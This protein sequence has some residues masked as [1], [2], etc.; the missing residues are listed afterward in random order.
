MSSLVA[1]WHKSIKEIQEFDW[2]ALS[3]ESVIP[4]YEWQWLD[5]LEKSRS[6]SPEQGWQ[7]LHLS[8]SRSNKLIAVAPLYLKGH[9]YGEFVFDQA[10]ARLAESLNVKYY[11]KL[12]GMS[13]LSPVEG[14]RFFIDQKENKDEITN[15]MMKIIDKFAIK[16][17]IC[18]CNFLYVEPYWRTLAEKSGCSTWLNQQSLWLANDQKNFSDYLASF[19]SNQRR[20]IKRERK[21]VKEAGVLISTLTGE[22]ID[23]NVMRNMHNFYQAHCARWGIWGS[24]YLSRTFFERLPL[25]S[26]RDHLILFNAH[27]G[28]PKDPIAMSLCVTNREKLWGRYWGSKEE[29]ECLHFEVCYY[30]PIEWALNNGIKS[31]DPGAGGN[32]KRRRGFLAKPHA[33]LHR[34]YNPQMKKLIKNW[35]PKVNQLML[36]EIDAIN[37]ELP[38][39]SSMPRIPLSG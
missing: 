29:V 28:N 15:L 9:S 19:N 13:P 10:F 24:K 21:S 5:T 32:H 27:K 17:G 38:F 37:A 20:N 23:T 26:Q 25:T 8:L 6:V 36:E 4:F 16:N 33:S 14:Y 3:G 39:H 11:P 31:F 34:W 30:S 1:N 12:L 7:P 18:S 2:Q 22:D 35:L